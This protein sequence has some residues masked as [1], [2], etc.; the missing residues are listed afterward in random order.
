MII[1]CE[2]SGSVDLHFSSL[3]LLYNYQFANLAGYILQHVSPG[4]AS[5][6]MV[7]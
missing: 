6:V 5:S 2:R 1:T 7:F 4:F 3:F